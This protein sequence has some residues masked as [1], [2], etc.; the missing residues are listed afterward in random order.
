MHLY[1]NFF[2]LL[3]NN[4]TGVVIY[5]FIMLA[6]VFGLVMSAGSF[7]GGNGEARYDRSFNISYDDRDHSAFS[8]GL[9]ATISENNEAVDMAGE[10][11]GRIQDLIFFNMYDIHFIIENGEVSYITAFSDNGSTYLMRNLVDRYKTTYDAYISMG[12][13]EEEAASKASEIILDDTQISVA[14][15]KGAA[16]GSGDIVVLYLNQYYGYIA[17][18]FMSLGVGYTVIANSN[19]LI[20]DRVD[21]SPVSRKKISFS[22]T[23]GLAS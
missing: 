2:K 23:L 13:G 3:K 7:M 9:I 16:Y 22:N 21:A 19:A 6:M 4:K 14:A 10:S 12:F 11:L 8:E 5:A 17:M 18:G 1:K 20:N 15:E